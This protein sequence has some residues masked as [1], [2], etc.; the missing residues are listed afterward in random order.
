M[1][2]LEMNAVHV[3]LFIQM[4]LDR[5]KKKMLG[6]TKEDMLEKTTLCSK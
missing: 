6:K 4:L 2:T 5:Q 3:T 1:S